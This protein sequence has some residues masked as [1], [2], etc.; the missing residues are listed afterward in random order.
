MTPDEML[1]ARVHA[2]P[3]NER[4][5]AR[6]DAIQAD[7]VHGALL[8]G[9]RAMG[10]GELR[11]FLGSVVPDPEPATSDRG[12]DGLCRFVE[13]LR[14]GK[15]RCRVQP[16]TETPRKGGRGRD[17]SRLVLVPVLPG[18][19]ESGLVQ[20]LAAVVANKTPGS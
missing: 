11:L 14:D 8:A 19:G 13:E 9:L 5:R 18:Q 15:L 4:L 2:A 7:P 20:V 10:H 17:G 6:A 1:P 16:S 12:L 3:A